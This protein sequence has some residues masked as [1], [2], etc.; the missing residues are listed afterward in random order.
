MHLLV[1]GVWWNC[2]KRGCFV[3]FTFYHSDDWHIRW[4]PYGRF[5]TGVYWRTAECSAPWRWQTWRALCKRPFRLELF[6]I[7][8]LLWANTDLFKQAITSTASRPFKLLSA[9]MFGYVTGR[10]TPLR[11]LRVSARVAT[12]CTAEPCLVSNIK[13]G[14]LWN[15]AGAS[16]GRGL[17][18]TFI[19]KCQSFLPGLT[20]EVQ[21]HQI[22]FYSRV[23]IA[24]R[25]TQSPT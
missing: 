13:P 16:T 25:W 14:N 4:S 1:D 19:W 11:L 15:W 10:P 7:S 18:F 8:H 12:L 22:R 20:C 23:H 5:K 21:R 6:V 3:G 24:V 17:K 2:L 9:R